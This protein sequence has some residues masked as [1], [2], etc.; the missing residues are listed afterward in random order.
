M[1]SKFVLPPFAAP[2]FSIIEIMSGL[3]SDFAPK[4]VDSISERSLGIV[5]PLIGPPAN[6]ATSCNK[7]LSKIKTKREFVIGG[8]NGSRHH[9]LLRRLSELDDEVKNR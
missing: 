5:S 6:A 9:R 1:D 4:F 7:T 2:M 3:N 8:D